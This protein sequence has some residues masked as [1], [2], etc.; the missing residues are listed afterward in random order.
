MTK[1]RDMV[2]GADG[3]IGD[4]VVRA[5]ELRAAADGGVAHGRVVGSRLDGVGVGACAHD[6]AGA[7]RLLNPVIVGNRVVDLDEGGVGVTGLGIREE[8]AS[9]ER[10]MTGNVRVTLG[11]VVERQQHPAAAPPERGPAV[12]EN[13]LFEGGALSTHLVGRDDFRRRQHRTDLGV[14][15]VELGGANGNRHCGAS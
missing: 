9:S 3:R 7:H 2:I 13:R 11:C 10:R 14:E 5:Y 1:S 6:V 4:G 15:R 8:D 12:G